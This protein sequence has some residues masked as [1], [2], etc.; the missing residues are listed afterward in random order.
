MKDDNDFESHV[1]TYH[2]S[3]IKKLNIEKMCTSIAFGFYLRDEESFIEFREKV[4]A[5]SLLDD[6]IFSVHEKKPEYLKDK[7]ERVDGG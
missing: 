7:A 6:C 4:I 2:C 3:N 5:L 1:N